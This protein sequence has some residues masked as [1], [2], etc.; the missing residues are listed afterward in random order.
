MLDAGI[1]IPL[2]G[3]YFL[4]EVDPEDERITTLMIY[5]L[6]PATLNLYKEKKRKDDVQNFLE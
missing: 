1:L 5:P 3:M 4:D 6:N 2:A